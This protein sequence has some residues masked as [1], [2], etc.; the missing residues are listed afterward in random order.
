MQEA[1]KLLLRGFVFDL[2]QDR[3]V[4]AR[5]ARRVVDKLDEMYALGDG[6]P[7]DSVQKFVSM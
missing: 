6:G 1:R 4:D 7:A 5:T 2:L 3:V